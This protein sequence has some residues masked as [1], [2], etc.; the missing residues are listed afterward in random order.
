[1]E[2]EIKR[3]LVRLNNR[4]CVDDIKKYISY[5]YDFYHTKVPEIIILAKKLHEEYELND[6]YK[7][8]NKLWKSN[9]H[10]SRVLAITA[11]QFYKDDF[12]VET[13]NFLKPKLREIR[14]LD[15]VDSIGSE[16]LGN[17]LLR[18]PELEPQII[19]LAQNKNLRIRRMALVST[20]PLIRQ[21]EFRLAFIL[22]KMNMNDIE[23]PTQK[24]VGLL[25]KEIGVQNPEILKRFLIKNDNLSG[26][27]FNSATENIKSFRK[28]RQI[29]SSKL[30]KLFF[31]K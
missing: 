6:F 18:Y 25:L 19:N 11:L 20:I 23:E 29:N 7:V 31:W 3:K 14:G 15:K 30:K 22:I 21:K 1:M 12:N 4:Q 10:N 26:I 8:F 17:I 16:I 28:L 2:Y 9:Y 27:A 5:S 24:T 13:W